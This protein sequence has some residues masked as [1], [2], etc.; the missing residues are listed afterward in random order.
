MI[1]V[2]IVEDNDTVRQ[3]LSELID[4]APSFRCICA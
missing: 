1:T 4:A 3:T 2:G